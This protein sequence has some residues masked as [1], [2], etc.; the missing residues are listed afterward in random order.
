MELAQSIATVGS[1]CDLSEIMTFRD[2]LT[3]FLLFFECEK[4]L[5]F[6]DISY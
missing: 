3:T 1:F 2:P 5:C 4:I 6:S